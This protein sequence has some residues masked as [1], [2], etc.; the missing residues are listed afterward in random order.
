MA[1]AADSSPSVPRNGTANRTVC[2][3]RIDGKVASLLLSL[4]VLALLS[5]LVGVPGILFVCP[6]GLVFSQLLPTPGWKEYLAN[7]RTIAFA[8]FIPLYFVAVGLKVN[9]PFVIA[10]RPLM[11]GLISAASVLK[12]VSGFPVVRSVFGNARGGRVTAL[13][14]TRLTSATVIPSLVLGLGLIIVGWYSLLISVVVVL[15]LASS[16]AVNS[17]PGFRSVASARG[18]FGV[19]DEGMSHERSGARAPFPGPLEL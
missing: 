5:R 7:V 11:L 8:L 9:L 18:L 3:S 6:M 17:F 14:N 4:A 2:Q 19:S 13:M 15:A 12:M 1:P 10:P 16:A